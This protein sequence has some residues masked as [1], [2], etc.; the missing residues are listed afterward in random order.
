MLFI[1]IHY[2]N[3]LFMIIMINIINSKIIL[4]RFYNNS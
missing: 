3:S 1:I 2:L 4:F